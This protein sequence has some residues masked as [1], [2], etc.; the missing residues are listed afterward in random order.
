MHR[1]LMMDRAMFF[2]MMYA[3]QGAARGATPGPNTPEQ[4]QD[5][6]RH[7]T[8]NRN[9]NKGPGYIATKQAHNIGHIELQR[10]ITNIPPY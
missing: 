10:A 5:N 6:K 1:I 2:K 3:G 8:R 7:Q 9:H 4:Q